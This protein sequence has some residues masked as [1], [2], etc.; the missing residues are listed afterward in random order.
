MIRQAQANTIDISEGVHAAVDELGGP[1]GGA[2]R[3]VVG[4][5]GQRREP[6]GGGVEG[7]A[8]AGDAEP[9]DDHVDVVGEVVEAGPDARPGAGARPGDRHGA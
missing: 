3:E 6:A 2:E 1:A 9:D 7:D 8:R 4:V 5:D